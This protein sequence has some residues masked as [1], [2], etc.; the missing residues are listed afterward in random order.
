L[1]R[2]D[3]F[4]VGVY[5]CLWHSLRHIARLLVLEDATDL[6]TAPLRAALGRFTVE[7]LPLTVVS[8]ALLGGLWL[9]MPAPPTDILGRLGLY[10][11]VIA[12][13][14]LPHTAVVTWM[15]RAQSVW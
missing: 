2:S 12:V 15:D 13:L 1:V 7:A 11:V 8:L 6:R 4:A 3:V 14:T 9:V 5:F 10:L